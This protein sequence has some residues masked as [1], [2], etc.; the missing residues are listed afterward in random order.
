[1]KKIILFIIV[2]LIIL[3]IATIAIN[4]LND[5]S[6]KLEEVNNFSYFRLYENEKYGVID[7]NGNILVPAKYDMLE[8]PNPSK[9]VFI[10]YL[11][12]SDQTSEYDTEVVNAQNE[13]ILKE[14]SR[15]STTNIKK[16]FNRSTIREKYF[17]LQR[18][19]KIWSYKL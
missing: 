3:T 4:K 8:I 16:R 9:D 12:Y 13:K 5:K 10:G 1:M 18:K 17:N 19:W 2:C 11:N 15:N 6:Y 7:S 14:Y